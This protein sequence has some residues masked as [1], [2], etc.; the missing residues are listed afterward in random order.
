MYYLAAFQVLCGGFCA[1]VAVRKGRS[2]VFWWLVG[3]VLP[4]VGV[5]LSLTVAPAERTRVAARGR[6]GSREPAGKERRIPRRCCGSYIPD[7]LGCPFFRRR[8]FPASP[9]EDSNTKGFCEHLHKELRAEPE[10]RGFR[11]TMEDR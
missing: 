5:V 6:R 1:F 3:T 9:R 8:L 7:C 2:P 10:R 4:V 11:V